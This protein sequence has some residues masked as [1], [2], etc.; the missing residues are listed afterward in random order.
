MWD[1]I[2]LYLSITKKPRKQISALKDK[3]GE[4]ISDPK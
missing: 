1:G 4:V 3:Q 2:N